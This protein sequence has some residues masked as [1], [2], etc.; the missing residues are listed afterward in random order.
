[1]FWDADDAF[2][3]RDWRARH[4]SR[5]AQDP[6]AVSRIVIIERLSACGK[7]LANDSLIERF[8]SSTRQ[9]IFT[10]VA[11]KVRITVIADSEYD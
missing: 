6:R 2:E 4:L 9:A 11:R 8:S 10:N 7:A 1:M 3:D 5:V